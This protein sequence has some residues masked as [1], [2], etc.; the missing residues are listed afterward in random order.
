MGNAAV[1]QSF[2]AAYPLPQKIAGATKYTWILTIEGDDPNAK[3]N[4][5]T[6]VQEITKID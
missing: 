3:N 4:T 5:F 1:G 2:N 6:K